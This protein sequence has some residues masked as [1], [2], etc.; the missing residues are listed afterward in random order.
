MTPATKPK[1]WP[2]TVEPLWVPIKPKAGIVEAARAANAVPELARTADEPV[3]VKKDPAKNGAQV[4]TLF[5]APRAVFINKL[6]VDAAVAVAK[7]TSVPAVNVLT[8]TV[9]SAA[10]DAT[11]FRSKAD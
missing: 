10:V 4:K 5:T 1:G 7:I 8:F 9:E 11:P 3:A 6:T 2:V